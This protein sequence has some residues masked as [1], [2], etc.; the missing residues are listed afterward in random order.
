MAPSVGYRRTWALVKLLDHTV[1]IRPQLEEV[2]EQLGAARDSLQADLAGR[3]KA[4]GITLWL[5]TSSLEA[6]G[7]GLGDGLC[8]KQGPYPGYNC[9]EIALC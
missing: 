8:G 9:W 5:M 1:D 2:R 7:F 6:S 3:V 4:I